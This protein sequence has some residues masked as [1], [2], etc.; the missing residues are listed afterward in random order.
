[1]YRA[2]TS[3]PAESHGIRTV[4]IVREFY[5][6]IREKRAAGRGAFARVNAR[7]RRKP[8]DLMQSAR[9]SRRDGRALQVRSF[10][11]DRVYATVVL[12]EGGG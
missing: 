2:V 3:S 11:R 1:M 5:A 8:I 9:R 12:A 10:G 4:D 6:D 7:R